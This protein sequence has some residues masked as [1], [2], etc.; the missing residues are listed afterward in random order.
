MV[1]CSLRNT[2]ASFI[3]LGILQSIM[4]KWR[5]KTPSR[6]SWSE[7]IGYNQP[8]DKRIGRLFCGVVIC[9]RTL[10]KWFI[11]CG[12]LC[13]KWCREILYNLLCTKMIGLGGRWDALSR[14]IELD[15]S[16]FLILFYF[17][18]RNRYLKMLSDLVYCFSFYRE[19]NKYSFPLLR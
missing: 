4:T 16:C 2:E 6:S 9:Y 13:V 10:L 12:L 8:K 3:S 7:V 18:I 19:L 1:L 11:L 15:C 17:C 14:K 5:C